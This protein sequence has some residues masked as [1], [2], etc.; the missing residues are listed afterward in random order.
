VQKGIV[1]VP[2]RTEISISTVNDEFEKV[3]ARIFADAKGKPAEAWRQSREKFSGKGW[4]KEFF[5]NLFKTGEAPFKSKLA[6]IAAQRLPS[7]KSLAEVIFRNIT[8]KKNQSIPLTNEYD[9]YYRYWRYTPKESKAD[10]L[11]WG[12]IKLETFA[13]EFTA[14]SHWS[15]DE[16]EQRGLSRRGN[17]PENLE[18]FKDP[19]DSGFAFYTR[20]KLFA[21]AF[22]EGNIRLTIANIPAGE[23][24]SKKCTGLVLTTSVRESIIFS[25]GFVMVH[26]EHPLF[27]RQM[28]HSTFKKEVKFICNAENSIIHA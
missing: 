22:R 21:L 26:N 7:E 10:P 9:G 27:K 28:S 19:E 13:N 4:G 18:E 20:S 16:I 25:A 5:R 2:K 15:F 23:K 1:I 6:L 12:I 24:Q 11:P 17:P 14:F 3:F 8:P